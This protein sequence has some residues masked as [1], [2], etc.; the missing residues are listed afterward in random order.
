MFCLLFC[1]VNHLVT[2]VSCEPWGISTSS[3]GA[4]A[5]N[6]WVLSVYSSA[7]DNFHTVPW[8]DSINLFIHQ[9]P[10][11]HQ[12]EQTK[13]SKTATKKNKGKEEKWMQLTVDW[14]ELPILKHVW[15]L[16]KLIFIHHRSKHYWY[17]FGKW[18]AVRQQNVFDYGQDM[19]SHHYGPLNKY[20]ISK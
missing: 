13:K 5:L 19:Q 9:K 1:L 20:F 3:F 10:S 6:G 2:D 8:K 15:S 11:I 4:T 7:A 14:D 16:C 18:L 17:C 12:Q